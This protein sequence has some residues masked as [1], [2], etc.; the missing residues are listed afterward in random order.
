[1]NT[2]N[3]QRHHPSAVPALS[4]VGV[5]KHYGDLAAN[6][7]VDLTVREG[8]VHAVLGENGAG[9]STLMRVLFGVERPDRG[10][11]HVR[12]AE[13]HFHSPRDAIDCG[14]GMVFQHFGLVGE[15]TALDNIALGAEARRILGVDRAA[16]QA[17]LERL[18]ADLGL[19]V[20]WQQRVSRLTVAQQQRVEILKALYRGANI[21]ILDEPTALLAPQERQSLFAAVKRLQ[22]EGLSVLF[23][24]HKLDEAEYLADDVTV[25]RAGRV[26]SHHKMADV[27][28][29]RLVKDMVG[30]RPVHAD[31]RP[32]Q[33]GERVLSV[34]GLVPVGRPAGHPTAPIDLQFYRREIVG[35]V[36][37]DGHGHQEFCRYLAGAERPARGVVRLDGTRNRK[38]TRAK[39]R[40]SGVAY[41]P[42]DRLASGV[43]MEH[44]ISENLIANR[45]ATREIVRGGM[46]R[47]ARIRER[48]AEL[49][50]QFDIRC[51]SSNQLAGRLSGGNIQ[52]VVLARELSVN[53]LIVVVCEPTRGLDV[54]AMANVHNALLSAATD[55][56]AVVAQS[57]DL[58]EILALCDR[59]VVFREHQIVADIA[60]TPQTTAVQ[61]GALMLGQVPE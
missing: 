59:I 53:P 20:P 32:R 27:T 8:T 50:A 21:L 46:L 5:W 29:S 39:A 61:V 12:G 1:M 36:G 11:I 10:S 24:T 18:S 37:I 44:S 33:R 6:R 28:R 4:L 41:V 15:L 58:D 17:R 45:L 35:V 26:I 40:D 3:E 54:G 22:A 48:A 13:K 34:E 2:I 57:S 49:I 14:I 30:D 19:A 55:G 52:K 42:E 38:W 9:K 25:M 47:R 56:A 7:D 43:A 23:I 31:Y 16:E 51:R 60:K